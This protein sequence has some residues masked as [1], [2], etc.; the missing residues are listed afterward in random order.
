MTVTREMVHEHGLTDLEYDHALNV[1]GRTPTLT[2]LGIISVMWSEH[3][4]YKSSRIHLATLPTDGPQVV[5]GPGENAGAVDIGGGLAAVFKMESHNHPS[6]IEPYQGAATGVGGILRDVFTMGA[7]PIANLNSLR[8]GRIDHPKTPHLFWGVVGG[9]AG[10]GNCVGVP[11]VGG[12]IYFDSCYDGNIL[13]N[14]FTLGVCPTDGIFKGIAA[15][16]GNP[17]FYVGAG[18]G[19][20]GIHGATMASAEFDAD[21]DE[22]RPTVQVGDPFREKLL[23]EACLELMQTGAIVGIQDMGAAG[24]TSSS[25]EMA[26]RGKVGL[27]LDIDRVPMREDGMTAYEAML[28][29]S[30]ERMLVVIE[31]GREDEVQRVFQKWEL[32]WAQVGEVIEEQ[33]LR[34]MQHGEVQAELPV[35]LLTSDAPQYDRPRSRPR[36]LDAL[37]SPPIDAPVSLEAAFIELLSSPNIGSRAP[38]WEQYDHMV[39]VGT[40]VN[41]GQAGA[42]VLRIPGTD[43]AVALAVDCNS[44]KVYVNPREGARHAVAECS[45]NVACTGAR[46]L[47]TTDC[48]NFGDPTV[49]EVMWQLVEAIAGLGEACRALDVPIV[50]GNVSLYNTT[51]GVSIY[52]TPTVAVVGAFEQPIGRDERG[53]VGFVAGSCQAAHDAVVLLGATDASDLGASEYLF[54][55]T[56]SIGASIPRIDLDAEARLQQLVRSLVAA[57]SIR[58]AHDCAEGGLGI[59]LVETVL[60]T[61]FGIELELEPIDRPDLW[62]F[63]ES[64]SRVIVST[65]SA[66]TVLAAAAAAGV[67]ATVIGTVTD[68]ALLRWRGLLEL[69][70][71][72]AREAH[73]GA[74]ARLS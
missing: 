52:P 5:Q 58:S 64:P 40:V 45:R 12:E 68:V 30:Q 17:V 33:V 20:D 59:A 42:A 62:L 36:Y 7:R 18:T 41:P 48:L 10:Y 63:S 51:D 31:E 27:L 67:P 28:S 15:G 6:F 23:I 22:K 47:G 9:I 43:R 13:V 49:P 60:G 56:G 35:G 14:A 38:V 34:V 39:G 32:E 55:R 8:F 73:A 4:S 46:P 24:L 72:D 26:D 1:L 37:S 65:P 61:P 19:R 2:E 44:R 11:T 71:D 16:I 69:V 70:L 66:D 29:E 74:L 21:S 53:D 25:V 3:C 50:G 57:R 54:L